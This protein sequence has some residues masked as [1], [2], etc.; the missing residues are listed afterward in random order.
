MPLPPGSGPFE[1]PATGNRIG[2]NFSPR[3]LPGGDTVRVMT[4]NYDVK[5]RT[6][7]WMLNLQGADWTAWAGGSLLIRVTPTKNSPPMLRVELKTPDD[8][9]TY[10]TRVPLPRSSDSSVRNRGFTDLR[11]PLV[12]FDLPM[13]SPMAELVVAFNGEEFGERHKTGSIDIHSI[14]LVPADTDPHEAR[15]P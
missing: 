4:I 6:V 5:S 15:K 2:A 9:S 3:V 11:V 8:K 14:R 13:M 12:E 1:D 10:W 7:G